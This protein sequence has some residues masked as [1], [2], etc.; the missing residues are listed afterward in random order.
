MPNVISGLWFERI[1]AASTENSGASGVPAE[2]EKK[3]CATEACNCR[4]TTLCSVS[5][6]VPPT[7]V[8]PNAIC[9][10]VVIR[11]NHSDR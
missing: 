11:P 5:V 8:P 7:V 2:V 6:A 4:S 9:W 1:E 10:R 3:A